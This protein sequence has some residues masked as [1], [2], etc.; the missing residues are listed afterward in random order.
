MAS[1][2][3]WQANGAIVCR[4]H[5]TPSD[6]GYDP[7]SSIETQMIVRM[8]Q[9]EDL[10][11]VSPC[12]PCEMGYGGKRPGGPLTFGEAVLTAWRWAQ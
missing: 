7:L 5:R 1:L 3:V 2:F 6:W 12:E 11:R 4:F 8:L 10:A 9:T